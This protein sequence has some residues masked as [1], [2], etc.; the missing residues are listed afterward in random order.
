MNA[1][2]SKAAYDVIVVGGGMGGLSAGALLAR[3]G[4]RVLVIEQEERAGID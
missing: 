1:E 4:K 3:A 2:A